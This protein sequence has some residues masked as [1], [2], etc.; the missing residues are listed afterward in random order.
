MSTKALVIN[1]ELI[2]KYFSDNQNLE[3][4]HAL[5][6]I[7][8]LRPVWSFKELSQILKINQLTLQEWIGRILQMN[9]LSMEIQKSSVKLGPGKVI[10][11]PSDE[12]LTILEKTYLAYIKG[13]I[14]FDLKE[15]ESLFELNEH[16]V[17]LFLGNFIAKGFVEVVGVTGNTYSMIT[18]IKIPKKTLESLEPLDIQILGYAMLKEQITFNDLSSELDITLYNVQTVLIDLILSE[19]ISVNFIYQK[20]RFKGSRYSFQV[21][22]TN[23]PF[24]ELPFHQLN[25]KERLL[26][27]ITSMYPNLKLQELMK[28]TKLPKHQILDTIS[29][30]TATTQ[31]KFKINNENVISLSLPPVLDQQETLT[32]LEENRLF[33]YRELVGR[34]QTTPTIKLVDLAKHMNTNIDQII[35]A[36]V[37]LYGNK[38]I[39][40]E[41]LNGGIFRLTGIQRD[42]Q[43]MDELLNPDEKKL[44]GMLIA[45]Q[46]VS[47]SMLRLTLNKSNEELNKLIYSFISLG[48]GKIGV[49][50]KKEIMLIQKIEI[51]LMTSIDELSGFQKEILGYVSLARNP[52]FKELSSIYKVDKNSLKDEIYFLIGSGIIVG[53]I[54][55]NQ[56]LPTKVR[57]EPP[58]A[59]I[60]SKSFLMQKIA[61]QLLTVKN[62]NKISIKS[63]AKSLK[64]D[65]NEVLRNL[66]V[67]TSEGFIIGTLSGNKLK[68]TKSLIK[69]HSK[70][71]C[72]FCGIEIK[73]NQEFCKS[74]GNRVI[75]CSVC[76]SVISGEE[77]KLKCPSCNNIAHEEHLIDWLRIKSE[78]PICKVK[79]KLN[80]FVKI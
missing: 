78:C 53:I 14:Q 22:Q 64:E 7:L 46:K 36:L 57:I 65:K 75:H 17:F 6:G 33:N 44:L 20:Q 68:L 39:N 58:N 11:A 38:I 24:V 59:S 67:L 47:W 73:R 4:V 21:I 18:K 30:L 74:C 70:F 37:V 10:F 60:E 49:K 3:L 1:K 45:H 61:E 52:N 16:Q 77:S 19:T 80:Q 28:L 5:I 8:S 26:V 76:R 35:K 63:I 51:P 50:N 43:T 41:F 31:Y 66:F 9:I 55:K 13:R 54:S 34:I 25:E 27:G 72:F 40:G 32:A 62:R 48:I 42:N 71:T 2:A 56:I 29:K 15:M 23:F 12:K 79:L 69:Y